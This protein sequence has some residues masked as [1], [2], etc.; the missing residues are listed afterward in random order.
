VLRHIYF[1]VRDEAWRTIPLRVLHEEISARPDG[2]EI[3]I[4]AEHREGPIVFR[5]TGNIRGSGD[6]VEF[7]VEG[8][9]ESR[10]LKNRI[11]LCVLHPVRG[12][13]G[14]PCRVVH[15]DGSVTDGTFP[16]FVSPHQPF[17]DVRSITHDAVPGL[18]TTVSFEGDVF[19]TEDQRNWT[20][21]SFK[22]YSTALALPFPVEVEAGWRVR[23]SVVVELSGEAA[24]TVRVDEGASVPWP[25]VGTAASSTSADL[26]GLGLRHVR[27]N[28]DL[29]L[30]G[31]V[32]RIAEGAAFGLPL[33]V[34]VHASSVAELAVVREACSGV[35]VARWIVFGVDASDAKEVFG[36]EVGSGSS[37]NF[38]ELNRRRE[39]ASGADFAVFGMSP[40]VHG[41]DALTI[42]ETLEGQGDAVRSALQFASRVAISPVQLLSGGGVDERQGS[43]FVAAWTIGSL[44]TLAGAGASSVTY[45]DAAGAR[46]IVGTP[47]E[48]VF[49]A[50][51]EFTPESLVRAEVSEPLRLAVLVLANADRR[52]VLLGNLTSDPVVV[53]VSEPYGIEMTLGAYDVVQVDR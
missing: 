44:A 27:V 50:I 51:A 49:G 2:F 19:E 41:V 5:W 25:A 31:W 7:A 16:E 11:G 32:E 42:V 45:F 12:C 35:E 46:G 22:T 4:E 40:Q 24:V 28:L 53:R 37:S 8:Q 13:A 38:V 34:A 14:Q 33:E 39:T 30:D 15:G 18:A 9:A 52:R 10:F 29:Q 1:A 43:A 21:G 47:V 6:R 48:S 36:G 3:A 23:Q 17:L 20:D 26:T